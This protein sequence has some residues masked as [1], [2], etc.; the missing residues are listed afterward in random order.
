[1][2]QLLTFNFPLVSDE[3]VGFMA[4]KCME[5]SIERAPLKQSPFASI[6][7]FAWHKAVGAESNPPVLLPR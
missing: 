6:D 2:D 1:M 7:L 4:H 5:P 3:N